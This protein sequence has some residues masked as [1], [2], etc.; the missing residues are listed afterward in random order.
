MAKNEKEI[1]PEV[2]LFRVS[3]PL[4]MG[5]NSST[6]FSCDPVAVRLLSSGTNCST[7]VQVENGLNVETPKGKY[8]VPLSSVSYIEYK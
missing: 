7:I 4:T 5:G 3:Q 6:T 2:K 8:F 1:Y